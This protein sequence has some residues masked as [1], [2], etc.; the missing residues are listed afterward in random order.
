MTAKQALI[1]MGL[2]KEKPKFKLTFTGGKFSKGEREK[3][4]ERAYEVVDRTCKFLKKEPVSVEIVYN[5]RLK[6]YGCLQWN[7]NPPRI[8]IGKKCFPNPE[9]TLAHEYVHLLDFLEVGYWDTSYVGYPLHEFYHNYFEHK[10]S[11]VATI[12][13]SEHPRSSIEKSI[14]ESITFVQ[15]ARGEKEVNSDI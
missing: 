6:T 8:E 14:L 9:L 4:L 3:F 5:G 1:K 15:F 2:W 7:A 10:A 11:G 13:Y 12:L